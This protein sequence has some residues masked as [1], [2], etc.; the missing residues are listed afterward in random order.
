[1]KITAAV[2]QVEWLYSS[3][4][5]QQMS[6]KHLRS[7]FNQG[8]SHL[9]LFPRITYSTRLLS[10]AQDGN[11]QNKETSFPPSSALME[12]SHH[13]EAFWEAREM[14]SYM[15][16]SSPELLPDFNRDLLPFCFGTCRTE[17]FFTSLSHD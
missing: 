13:V 8:L 14:R 16:A 7:V 10:G 17:P 11:F 12:I 6:L 2:P 3:L 15:E 1:M 5:Q 4:N 9:T